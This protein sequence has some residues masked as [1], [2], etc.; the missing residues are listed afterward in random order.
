MSNNKNLLI[1]IIFIGVF[2]SFTY[3]IGYYSNKE[4]KSYH[5]NNWQNIDFILNH[6]MNKYVD[7]LD[8]N[9]LSQKSIYNILKDLDPHSTYIPSTDVQSVNEELIGHFGGIG[10][11]FMILRD[12]LTVVDVIQDGPSAEKGLR[13]RDR[14]IEVDD[15]NVA[16]I[17]I[18]NKDVL[19]KLKGK[20]GS[21]VKLKILREKK[22]T[23]IKEIQRGIIP[24]K[25][26]TAAAMIDDKNGYIKIASFSNNTDSEFESALTSLIKNG[27][28][29]L[30]LD[31]RFNG[32]GYLHQAINIA[33]EFLGDR[34]LIVYTEGA[35]SK[36]QT[37]YATKKGGFEYG[38]LAIL[39]NSRTASASEIVS[40][41]IQDHN[42]GIIVGRRT[43]GKGLVQQPVLLPDSSELR[44]TTSRYYTPSGKCIQK[45]YGDSIDYGNDLFE[46]LEN[47]ELTLIDSINDKL[48]KKGGIWPDIFSPIDTSEFNSVVSDVTFSRSWRNFCFDFYEKYPEKP[49]EDIFEFFEKFKVKKSIFINYFYENKLSLDLLKNKVLK[50][51]RR[52]LMLEI[53]SYYYNDQSRYILSALDD[54]DVKMAIEQLNI[55]T[56]PPQ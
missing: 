18:T 12:T 24:L 9:T 15:K 20:V 37:Y 27:M 55:N 3:W 32:G 23:L 14:I 31:L 19:K 8:K 17:G 45:P 28:V 52:S 54:N 21:N 11:R 42:R 1:S 34:K 25:S 33:D 29:N 7:T 2:S 51:L 26:I 56:E 48:I 43:F 50:D 36:K 47:G 35:H 53:C 16:G 6:L 46:R 5:S 10:I 38:K 22:L 30:I 44:I 13:K 41:A 4:I 40:G 49:F 39:V